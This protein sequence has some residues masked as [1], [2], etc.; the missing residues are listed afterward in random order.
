M[1]SVRLSAFVV[2]L[3]VL[4]GGLSGQDPKKDDP[5]SARK[6]EPSGRVKG[7]LPPQWGKLGLTDDQKQKVY[8]IQAKYRDEISK[9]EEQIKELRGKMAK[10]QYEVLTPDQK[11]RLDEL[12]S[13]K[14]GEKNK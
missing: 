7:Q 1:L 12:R 6:D 3:L 11:K 10:E 14:P 4:T 13:A 8:K 5:K 9:L 2:G